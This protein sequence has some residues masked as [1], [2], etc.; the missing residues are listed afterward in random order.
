MCSI[1][2]ENIDAPAVFRK[3]MWGRFEVLIIR[4]IPSLMLI[5]SF[6]FATCSQA[7]RITLYQREKR[8]LF[9]EKH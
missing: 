8:Y 4:K 1:C 2:R 9:K 3:K 7:L 5:F 6:Y